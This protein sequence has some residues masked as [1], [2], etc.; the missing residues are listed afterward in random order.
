MR[1]YVGIDPGPSTGVVVL[2]IGADGS[3]SWM[4][5]QVNGEAAFWL[6]E[7][8]YRDYCPRVVAIEEFIPTSKAGTTGKDAQLTRRIADHAYQLALTIKRNPAAHAR[9]RNAGM[10]KPWASDHRL[11]KAGFPL[12]A[13][14]LDARDAAR[15]AMYA[16]VYDGKE[17]DPLA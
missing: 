11:R 8:I 1:V 2:V 15:H 16:A 3:W 4:A 6:I 9:K 17:R 5:F 14:F 13:K 7:S 12:G 10:I